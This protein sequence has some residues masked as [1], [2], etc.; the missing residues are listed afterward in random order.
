VGLG[1]FTRSMAATSLS[2]ATS[3]DANNGG[4]TVTVTRWTSMKLIC[5]QRRSPDGATV[6]R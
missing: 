1:G 3:V 6:W 5:F 2:R 4:L